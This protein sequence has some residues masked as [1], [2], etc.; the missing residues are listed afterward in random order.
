VRDYGALLQRAG[1][2][3]P[4]TD[5][6]EV[7]VR[8]SDMFAL[9]RDLRAMGMT[10]ALLSERSRTAASQDRSFFA[11]P[12]FTPSGFPIPTDAFAP[13]FRSFTSRD[14]RRMNSQQKPLRPGAAKARLA[15]ALKTPERKLPR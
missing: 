3:L 9:L 14:G 13:A 5:I 6:E 15:D 8:Y 11:P 4:V 7:V 10:S 12:R 1:F 2:A